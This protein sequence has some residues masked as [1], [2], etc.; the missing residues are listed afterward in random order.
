MINIRRNH[1]VADA[2][3]EGQKK[4]FNPHK[5]VKVCRIHEI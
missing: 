2:L 1:L 3:K 5:I 4:K